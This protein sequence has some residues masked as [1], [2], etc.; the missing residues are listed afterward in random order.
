MEGRRAEKEKAESF[1]LYGVSSDAPALHSWGQ[2]L[3]TIAAKN[4]PQ[5][6]HYNTQKI[7]R[8]GKV[9]HPFSRASWPNKGFE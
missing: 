6:E 2:L 9:I 8:I 3:S 5:L 4:I 7:R 1:C